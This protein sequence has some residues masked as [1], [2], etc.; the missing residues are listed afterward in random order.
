MGGGLALHYALRR[1]G[2]VRR[3]VLINPTG[4][5]SAPYLAPLKLPPRSLVRACGSRLAPRWL[6]RFVLRHLAYCDTSRLTP[7][8]V[9]EYWSPSQLTGYVNAAVCTFKE[10]D[11]RPVPDESVARLAAPT[12]VIL[13]TEDRLIRS[14]RASAGKLP[15]ARVYEVSGGHC[16]H[17]ERPEQVYAMIGEFLAEGHSIKSHNDLN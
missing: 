7:R 15:G 13:G 9:D 16:V 11:W 14:A 10:F 8:V 17:E 6:F 12:V 2:R 1:P 3:L 5:V 4:L